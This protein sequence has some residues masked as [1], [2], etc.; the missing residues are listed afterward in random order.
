MFYHGFPK[1]YRIYKTR[2]IYAV[3]EITKTTNVVTAVDL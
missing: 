2:S 3:Q 1:V